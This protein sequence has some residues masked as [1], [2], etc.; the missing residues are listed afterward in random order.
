MSLPLHI[1]WD[2]FKPGT[3]FFVPCLDRT[4][5]ERMIKKEARR[6]GFNVATRQVIE[7]GVYGLRV[8]RISV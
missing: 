4:T 7:K 8:W 1:H 6:L 3:S 2:K 5:T